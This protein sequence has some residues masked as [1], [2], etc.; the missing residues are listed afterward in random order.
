MVHRHL[1]LGTPWG[2]LFV[3]LGVAA[4]AGPAA[5]A[6]VKHFGVT[7]GHDLHGH[8]LQKVKTSNIDELKVRHPRHNTSFAANLLPPRWG[9]GM[10]WGWWR[11][12]RCQRDHTTTTSPFTDPLSE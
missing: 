9:L 2:V 7:A 8:D 4:A 10:W 12:E 1:G 6:S 11:R 5:P 3:G